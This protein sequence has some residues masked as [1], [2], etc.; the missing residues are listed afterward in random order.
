MKDEMT[1]QEVEDAMMMMGEA[2]RRELER[3]MGDSIDNLYG[4]PTIFERGEDGG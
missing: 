4:E 2:E 1:Q 3:D